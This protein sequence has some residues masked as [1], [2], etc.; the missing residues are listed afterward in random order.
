MAVTL[1]LILSHLEHLFGCNYEFVMI[2]IAIVFS[3]ALVDVL[4]MLIMRI[5]LDGE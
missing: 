2:A 3:Q 1:V 5:G 4:I